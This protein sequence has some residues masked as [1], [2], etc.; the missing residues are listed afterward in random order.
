MSANIGHVSFDLGDSKNIVIAFE[1]V[2]L[3]T[4]NLRYR[5]FRLITIAML[6]PV[7]M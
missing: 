7:P 6:F 4:L 2:S 1:A 5:N 3:Y